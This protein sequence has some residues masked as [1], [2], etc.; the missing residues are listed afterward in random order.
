MRL[1]SRAFIIAEIPSYEDTSSW[2]TQD[3]T[4]A[5]T[6][7]TL[8][9]F[10]EK[11]VRS[12]QHLGGGNNNQNQKQTTNLSPDKTICFVSVDIGMG[13]DLLTLRVIKRLEE[14]LP[15]GNGNKTL[16][17]LENT[18]IS[19][20]HTHSAP[21]GFLQYALYQIT[22]LGFSSETLDTLVE[23]ISKSILRAY[24]NLQPGTIHSSQ[25][26]LFGANRNRSPTSYMLNPS[27]ERYIYKKEGD[28]DKNMVL[29]KFTGLDK[30][31][32]NTTTTNNMGGIMQQQHNGQLLGTLSWY[33]VHLTSMNNTNL[34]G[35]ENTLLYIWDVF[36]FSAL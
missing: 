8:S 15:V 1:R 35:A 29:L 7:E 36:F 4:L 21:G 11:I 33:A 5:E 6:D 12:F 23:G 9:S 18:S 20:T 14:L 13:S 16:C 25:G 22:S 19:G 27:S 31:G 34:V 3:T 17:H 24:Q 2:K 30:R 28:T 10:K 26:L 32:S